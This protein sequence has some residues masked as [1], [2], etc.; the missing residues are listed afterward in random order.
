MKML[1]EIMKSK[2]LNT[3]LL[4]FSSYS[5]ETR[6]PPDSVAACPKGEPLARTRSNAYSSMKQALTKLTDPQ[7]PKPQTH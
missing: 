3:K 2:Y 7:S 5:A 6:P 1:A 4:A